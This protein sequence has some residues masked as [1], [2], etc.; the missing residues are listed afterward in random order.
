VTGHEVHAFAA[1]FVT[2]AGVAA[3][4][5]G[6]CIYRPK[7][8]CWVCKRHPGRDP[9]GRNWRDCWWCHGNGFRLR[10]GARLYKRWTKGK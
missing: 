1:V 7:T 4:Y 3:V 2:V 6:S 9:H 5:M 8:W 10:Y